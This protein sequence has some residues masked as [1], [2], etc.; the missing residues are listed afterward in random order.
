M[1]KDLTPNTHSEALWFASVHFKAEAIDYRCLLYSVDDIIEDRLD[2]L[3][4][5]DVPAETTWILALGPALRQSR[6]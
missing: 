5:V 4:A 6:T 2:M 3:E 1:K